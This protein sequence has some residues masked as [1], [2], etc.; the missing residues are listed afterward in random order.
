MLSGRSGYC[1]SLLC[2]L[3]GPLQCAIINGQLIT[4]FEQS[5]GHVTAHVPHTDET[6]ALFHIIAFRSHHHTSFLLLYVLLAITET[7]PIG[8][9]ASVPRQAPHALR[10]KSS[11]NS[12]L[13]PKRTGTS[14]SSR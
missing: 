1:G 7:E 10:S 12:S 13:S 14:R 3:L 6:N 11:T 5:L 2:Y 8:P 4:G 9:L